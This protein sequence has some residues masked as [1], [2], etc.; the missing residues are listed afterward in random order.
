[1]LND[2]VMVNVISSVRTKND[3]NGIPMYFHTMEQETHCLRLPFNLTC[4]SLYDQLSLKLKKRATELELIVFSRCDNTH[5][6]V[7][8]TD[9]VNSLARYLNDRYFL[10]CFTV[11]AAAWSDA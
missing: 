4:R 11:R 8:P 6:V 3:V 7:K 10:L 1:M 9:A 2:V 5:F